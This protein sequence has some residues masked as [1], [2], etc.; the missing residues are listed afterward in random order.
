[1][2][3]LQDIDVAQTTIHVLEL[4]YYISFELRTKTLNKK[5]L[6]LVVRTIL[7]LNILLTYPFGV[8]LPFFLPVPNVNLSTGEVFLYDFLVGF[9]IDMAL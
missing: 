5:L 1:M 8:Y 4:L 9:I 2:L 7:S 3:W 6:S